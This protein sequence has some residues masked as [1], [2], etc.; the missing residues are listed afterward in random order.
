MNWASKPLHRYFWICHRRADRSFFYKGKQFPVCARCTGIWLGYATGILLTTIIVPAIWVAL[1]LF[2]PMT[3]DVLTQLVHW[4]T[5]ANPLRLI[6]GVL[7]GVGE[8]IIFI[9]I[10]IAI[11]QLGYTVGTMLTV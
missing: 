9:Y 2:I 4:R 1:L 5:S 8:V 7:G 10:A 6:T 3:I 11:T